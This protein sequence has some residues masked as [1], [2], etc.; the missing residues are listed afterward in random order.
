MGV[1]FRGDPILNIDRKDRNTC[2]KENR[3]ASDGIVDTVNG[4]PYL[5]CRCVLLYIAG[6]FGIYELQ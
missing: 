4:F 1:L 5:V 3:G 6:L 2:D